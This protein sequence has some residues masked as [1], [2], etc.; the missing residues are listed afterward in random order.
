[1]HL[2]CIVLYITAKFLDT[3]EKR[4]IERNLL[5]QL[6]ATSASRRNS[7]VGPNKCCAHHPADYLDKIALIFN[8]L[9]TEPMYDMCYYWARLKKERKKQE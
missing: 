6:R 2:Y 5:L 9:R 7:V 1:M 8:Q 4:E 3:Q